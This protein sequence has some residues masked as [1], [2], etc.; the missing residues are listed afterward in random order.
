MQRGVLPIDVDLADAGIT[1][2][3]R[4][5]LYKYNILVLLILLLN[6]F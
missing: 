2:H 4:K 5:S 1:T 6:H 3:N